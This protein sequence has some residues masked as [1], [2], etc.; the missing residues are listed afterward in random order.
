MSVLTDVDPPHP[1]P[2]QV[3][4]HERERHAANTRGSVDDEPAKK[5]RHAAVR[6]HVDVRNGPADDSAANRPRETDDEARCKH[7][8]HVLCSEKAVSYRQPQ[9]QEELND[10]MM[11]LLTVRSS[12]GTR[13]RAPTQTNTLVYDLAPPIWARCTAA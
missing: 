4:R 8:G 9:T 5:H 3:C 10:S 2:S 6:R 11:I 1:S 12:C 13:R 7:G